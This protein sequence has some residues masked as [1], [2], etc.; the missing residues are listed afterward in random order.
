GVA[1]SWGRGAGCGSRRNPMYSDQENT[2]GRARALATVASATLFAFNALFTF[3]A[4]P[5]QATGLDPGFG[6][7]GLVETGFGHNARPMDAALQND[8]KL[9]TTGSIDDFVIATQAAQVVRYLPNGSLDGGFGNGGS[10]V[11][12]FTNFLNSGNAVAIQSNGAIV[13]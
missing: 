9:V 5:S 12:A 4:S 2:G 10:A 11:V 1:L 3:R 7:G 6:S 8:G 13:I